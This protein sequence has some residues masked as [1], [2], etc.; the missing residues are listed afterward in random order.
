[1]RRRRQRNQCLMTRRMTDRGFVEFALS[2]SLT[3]KQQCAV[4]TPKTAAPPPAFE[5]L[6][7]QRSCRH[8]LNP[9]P[10]TLNPQP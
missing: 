8:H 9:K 4:K 1:M 7:H 3:R 5:T 2:S 10:S 6:A